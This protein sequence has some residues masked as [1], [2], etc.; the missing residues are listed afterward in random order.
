EIGEEHA[1]LGI[2]EVAER[3]DGFLVEDGV[4]AMR[5]IGVDEVAQ[6]DARDG[7]ARLGDP[8]DH[9]VAVA[10]GP[11]PVGAAVEEQ[12]RHRVHV[13]AL[14]PE[15]S[16]SITTSSGPGARSGSSSIVRLRGPLK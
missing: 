7:G 4:A 12:A 5:R 6:L 1:E 3:D 9:G 16:A 8:A 15:T 13:P 10:G 14:M 2:L 11:A